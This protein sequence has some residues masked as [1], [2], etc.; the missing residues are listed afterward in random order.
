MKK[1]SILG[2]SNV[3]MMIYLNNS[4]EL[5]DPKLFCGGTAANVAYGL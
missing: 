1:I 3:D 5:A 2:D 4:T